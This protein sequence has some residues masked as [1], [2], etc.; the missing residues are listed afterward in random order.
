M[1]KFYGVL[2]MIYILFYFAI[3]ILALPLLYLM[4]LC[5]RGRTHYEESG[6]DN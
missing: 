3:G 4:S 6:Y 1:K 5:F 2:E